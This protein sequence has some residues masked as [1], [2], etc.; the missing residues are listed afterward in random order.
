MKDKCYEIIVV[1]K[2]KRSFEKKVREVYIANLKQK[3][4]V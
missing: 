3:N 4:L 2:K 1:P